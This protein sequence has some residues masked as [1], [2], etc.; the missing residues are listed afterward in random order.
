MTEEKKVIYSNL[1]KENNINSIKDDYKCFYCNLCNSKVD[2]KK[3]HL[4]S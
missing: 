2:N 4:K 3:L 1:I